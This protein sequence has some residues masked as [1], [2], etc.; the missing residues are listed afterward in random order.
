MQIETHLGTISRGSGSSRPTSPNFT[1]SRE[2]IQ[3]SAIARHRFLPFPS[4]GNPVLRVRRRAHGAYGRGGATET[5]LP[6]VTGLHFEQQTE[7]SLCAALEAFEGSEDG[8]D[9]ARI[10]AHA[11]SFDEARFSAAMRREVARAEES[12]FG[13][14]AGGEAQDCGRE[15]KP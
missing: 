9:A 12:I 6:G 1:P 11:L 5:V 10:R 7:E 15:E 2:L 8:F 4:R 3:Y 14:Q 13:P